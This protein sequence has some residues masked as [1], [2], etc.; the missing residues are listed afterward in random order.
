M[1]RDD[2]A[3]MAKVGVFTVRDASEI[4][5]VSRRKVIQY[6]ELGFVH[7]VNEEA[8]SRGRHRLLNPV[9][10]FRIYIAAKLER[11]GF[12]LKHINPLLEVVEGEGLGPLLC[13]EGEGPWLLGI[14]ADGAGGYRAIGPLNME[15]LS[16]CD[17]VVF[18]QLDVIFEEFFALL[19]RLSASAYAA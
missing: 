4:A 5:G 1:H 9:G 3:E 2:V 8:V 14:C 6:V 11:V 19:K 15:T 17:A 13:S 18:L 12:A 7:P 10:L 16:E